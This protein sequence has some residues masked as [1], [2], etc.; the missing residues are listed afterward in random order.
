MQSGCHLS[1]AEEK[2][3]AFLQQH[4]QGIAFNSISKLSGL[5]NVSSPAKKLQAAGLVRLKGNTIGRFHL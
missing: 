2:L 1:P 5:K 4:P 3:F